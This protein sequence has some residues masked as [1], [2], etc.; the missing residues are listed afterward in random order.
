MLVF[1]LM[2]ARPPAHGTEKSRFRAGLP[3]SV[4][5]TPHTQLVS[6]VILDPVKLIIHVSWHICLSENS[7]EVTSACPLSSHGHKHE[8]HNNEK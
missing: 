2:Q 8:G 7:W 1:L 5:G 4:N 3:A 6:W